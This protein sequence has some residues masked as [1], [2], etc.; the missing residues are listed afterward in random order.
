MGLE[1]HYCTE[2]LTVHHFLAFP[3]IS[4]TAR[5][6]GQFGGG[7]IGPIEKQ[8]QGQL[9]LLSWMIEQT[10]VVPSLTQ[11]NCSASG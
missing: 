8:N 6:G 11:K 7:Q 3:R 5:T 2:P 9:E 1:Q 10:P 4:V